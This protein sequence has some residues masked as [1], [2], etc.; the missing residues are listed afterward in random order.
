MKRRTLVLGLGSI[1]LTGTS[2]LGSG[3]FSSVQADRDVTVNVAGDADALLALEPSDGPNGAYA[4]IEGD[5]LAL[6]FD[7]SAEGVDGEGFNPNA[8]TRVDDIFSITNQGT[9]KVGVYIESFDTVD[10]VDVELLAQ[11]GTETSIVGADAA[12]GLPVGESVPV[13]LTVDVDGAGPTEGEDVIDGDSITIV[14]TVEEDEA[15]EIEETFHAFDTTDDELFGFEFEVDET[16]SG[17]DPVDLTFGSDVA[18]DLTSEDVT[19]RPD[20]GS[21]NRRQLLIRQYDGSTA[22]VDVF[23]SIEI[24]ESESVVIDANPIGIE[25]SDEL[26]PNEVTLVRDGDDETIDAIETGEFVE[27]QRLR[28]SDLAPEEQFTLGDIEIEYPDGTDFGG[29][30]NGD[31]NLTRQEVGNDREPVRV[32]NDDY[33]GSEVTL[34]VDQSGSN[35]QEFESS[36]TYSIEI[37]IDTSRAANIEPGVVDLE[38]IDDDGETVREFTATFNA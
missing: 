12:V 19:F 23:G 16:V 33:S 37:S 2:I 5:T 9:Q 30:D 31:F 34:N 14:A 13:G 29:T 25:D 10:D 24:D 8:F 11:N 1:G 7:G 28:I 21:G 38:L 4:D 35:N 22:E 18:A 15:P 20:S 3:A 32:S 26:T 17:V 27:S 6:N 36:S